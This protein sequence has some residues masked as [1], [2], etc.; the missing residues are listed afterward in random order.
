MRRELFSSAFPEV[1]CALAYLIAPHQFAM[2]WHFSIIYNYSNQ[3]SC[4]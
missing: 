3:E 4:V 2:S 1:V